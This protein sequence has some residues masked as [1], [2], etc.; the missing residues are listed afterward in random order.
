MAR[1]TL[2]LIAFVVALMVREASAQGKQT[3]V[4]GWSIDAE[5]E[6]YP[7]GTNL[8]FT[9]GTW[10]DYN[11]NTEYVYI[12]HGTQV[13]FYDVSDTN[14]FDIEGQ[15]T[16]AY[17]I[18]SGSTCAQAGSQ[19][20]N[21]LMF[22]IHGDFPFCTCAWSADAPC[23]SRVGL[24]IDGGPVELLDLGTNNV[25]PIDTITPDICGGAALAFGTGPDD[26]PDGT[27][28]CGPLSAES[29]AA[30]AGKYCVVDR[31]ACFFNDKYGNCRDAGAIGTLIVNRDD[32][33]FT[34]S[35]QDVTKGD[36]FVIIGNTDGQK[37][38]DNLDTAEVCLGRG[39][40]VPEALPEYQAPDGMGVVNPRT[41]ERIVQNSPFITA[42]SWVIDERNNVMYAFKVDGSYPEE[43][44]VVDLSQVNEN[45]LYPSLGLFSGQVNGGTW[46]LFYQ[47]EGPDAKTFLVEEDV[48]GGM[49]YIYGLE[50]PTSPELLSSIA[51]DY[52]CA[53]MDFDGVEIV[54]G[55]NYLIMAPGIFEEGCDSYKHDI[56]DISD[57]S[58]PTYVSSFD[59]E[60]IEV[61]AL[62]KNGGTWAWG[63]NNIVCIPMTSAGAVFYDFTDPT[64][65]VSF[66]DVFN[67]AENTNDF[68]KGIFD[69]KYGNDG[70]WYIF[71]KDGVDG[72]HAEMHQIRVVDPSTL[73]AHDQ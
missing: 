23:P 59:V 38:K 11:S 53:T 65:P 5:N 68:T 36:P 57:P 17:S 51:Y 25:Q 70:S 39:F 64:A 62:T 48:F 52:S 41:G 72:Q 1:F 66:S 63:P 37:I 58:N 29:A 2:V 69:C 50:D 47:G 7:I 43:H 16:I 12:H 3:V 44:M 15:P 35:V 13:D 45:G 46:T 71:E 28:G 54:R 73:C 34:L 19:I 67:P 26:G 18:P 8:G 22:T 10:I 30:V 21:D 56:Y 14:T 32:S 9:Y 4:E 49:A 31:G 60:E 24:S 40:G 55:G 6:K 20:S 27:Y 61:G 42:N 33:V